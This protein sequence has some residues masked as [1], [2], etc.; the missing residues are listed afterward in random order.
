MKKTT[1]KIAELRAKYN[2]GML[3]GGEGFNPYDQKILDK[4]AARACS[5]ARITFADLK[6]ALKPN[7]LTEE[8][9]VSMLG[10]EI[11]EQVKALNCDFTGRV[12]DD[13][14]GVVEMAASIDITDGDYA[15]STLVINYLVDKDDLDAAGNDLNNC[16]FSNYTYTFEII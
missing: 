13:C 1:G 4:A 16:D 6:D 3:E 10:E 11:V 15:W 5:S 14:F 9:V 7:R 12:I 2:R 8:Q